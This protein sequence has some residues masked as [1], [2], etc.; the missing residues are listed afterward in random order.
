MKTVLIGAAAS[1]ALVSAT[2]IAQMPG[3]AE[4]PGK[5]Q[6][7]GAQSPGSQG[8]STQGPGS[9]GPSAKQ[10]GGKAEGS[11]APGA[12]K[13]EAQRA[14]DAGK[15]TKESQGQGTPGGAKGAQGPG[16]APS[17][18]KDQSKS[19][20][21]Q[22]EKGQPKATETRPEKG[23]PKSTQTQPE[24]G[25]PKS[26][27]TQP[28]KGQKGAQGQQQGSQQTSRVQVSEQER[29]GVRDRLLK[30]G[31]FQKTKLNVSVNVGTRVPQ[32]VR[33]L[34]LPVAIIDLAPAY[35]GYSYVVLEDET[36]CII[37]PRSHA[38]VDIIAVG[39]Q[40]AERP[41]RVTLSLTQEQMRFIAANVPKEPRANVRVRLALGAEVPR[42]VELLAFPGEVVSQ[43]PEV[44][45]YRYIVAE[46]DVVI[47]D[48]NGRGVALVI[49]E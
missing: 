24:K 19:T 12:G 35:R 32:S 1:I 8:P 6:G 5:M 33:L 15:G 45:R 28:E 30:E 9:Q 3:G 31:K 7:P 37:D 36:I 10:P 40:R 26:T 25:Q 49:S 2:A 43:I 34:P 27:Q 18:G 48:P 38:I 17:K 44:E 13:G 42:N 4:P 41:Q 46:N 29:S 22:P 47:V 11:Q 39:T 20:Q 23:Q 14:P 16:E 21:G